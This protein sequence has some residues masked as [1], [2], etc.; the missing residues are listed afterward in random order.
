MFIHQ[1]KFCLF[2]DVKFKVNGID[3]VLSPSMLDKIF[4]RDMFME[5]V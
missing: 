5:G 2:I 1:Y 3:W 4:T